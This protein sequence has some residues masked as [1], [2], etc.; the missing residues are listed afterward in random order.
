MV[1]FKEKEPT[2]P[3]RI[4]VEGIATAEELPSCIYCP[5]SFKS[6]SGLLTHSRLHTG[7]KPFICVWCYKTFSQKVHKLVHTR[8]HTGEKPYQCMKCSKCFSL[9]SSLRSHLTF[10]HTGEEPYQC[11]KCGKGFPQKWS[12]KSHLKIHTVERDT[13][14]AL[15]VTGVLLRQPLSETI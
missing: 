3:L 1:R 12:L 5:K 14:N 10:N 9:S 13:T 6:A 15:T 11:M 4:G 7:E 2:D 8:I